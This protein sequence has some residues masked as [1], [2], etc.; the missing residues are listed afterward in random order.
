MSQPLDK[1]TTQLLQAALSQPPVTSPTV[2]VTVVEGPSAGLRIVFDDLAHRQV[3]VGQSATCDVRLADKALSRATP[4][5]P[6]QR[7]RRRARAPS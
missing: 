1:A 5:P 3:F 6:A 4:S 7:A 2:T